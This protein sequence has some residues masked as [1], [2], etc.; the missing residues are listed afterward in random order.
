MSANKIKV[1][2]TEKKR[3][4]KRRNFNNNSEEI[5]QIYTFE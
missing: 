1:T 4:M 5:R 3:D 2:K